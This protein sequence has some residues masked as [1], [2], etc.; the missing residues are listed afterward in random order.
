MDER[1]ASAER[2]TAIGDGVLDVLCARARREGTLSDATLRDLHVLFDK[3]LQ[4]AVDLLDFATI[5]RLSPRGAEGRAFWKV[6]STS[7]SVY[8]CFSGYCS[9]QAFAFLVAH[10]SQSLCKH[11]LA[12]RLADTTGRFA[13][14]ELDADMWGVELLR[15]CGESMP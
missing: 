4:S 14:Q 11:Q 5:T 1:E 12:V 2:A 13:R 8:H 15:G 7:G 3:T 9:C 6:Q 10:T